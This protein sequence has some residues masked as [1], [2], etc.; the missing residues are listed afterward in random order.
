MRTFLEVWSDPGE[1]GRRAGSRETRKQPRQP[2]RLASAALI[3][4]LGAVAPPLAWSAG[5]GQDQQ[6]PALGQPMEAVVR[7]GTPPPLTVAAVMTRPAV[8]TP[9]PSS[10]PV[11]FALRIGSVAVALLATLLFLTRRLAVASGPPVEPSRSR[12]PAPLPVKQEAET[13]AVAANPPAA[14]APQ[15]SVEACAAERGPEYIP[16]SCTLKAIE[17]DDS[18][19][20]SELEDFVL[21]ALGPHPERADLR[22]KLLEFYHDSGDLQAFNEQARFYILYNKGERGFHWDETRRMG[23]DL[24]PAWTLQKLIGLAPNA[25]APRAPG[26]R[27]FYDGLEQ[28]PLDAALHGLQR[29][30]HA[31]RNDPAFLAAI[32]DACSAE[33]GQPT[34]YS[35]SEALSREIGGARIYIKREDLR[36]V[37][38]DLLLNA[39][40]QVTLAKWSGHCAAVAGFEDRRHAEA[41]ARAARSLDIAATICVPREFLARPDQPTQRV[42]KQSGAHLVLADE[43]DTPDVDGRRSAM[44]R[45]LDAP[46]ETQYVSSLRT[47][48][49]PFPAM[50]RDFQ[51]LI[52]QEIR[53]QSF[54]QT[55][56]LPD[57]IVANAAAGP[58]AFGVIQS[59]L[60]DDQVRID[61]VEPQDGLAAA[62]WG[63]KAPR[64][65]HEL[66]WSRR[67]NRVNFCPVGAR[68]ITAMIELCGR[69]GEA[70]PDPR[71]ACTL[72]QAI[73][74][75]RNAPRESSVMALF[76]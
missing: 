32:M 13:L 76:A 38:A 70:V 19:L 5:P 4:V 69:S 63:G 22:F 43:D 61:C 31:A 60:N 11:D 28:E 55:G 44:R 15:A 39:L 53:C 67:T 36:P 3:A 29:A 54:C 18:G 48:P 1:I 6:P 46:G 68:E 10:Q 9:A 24:D 71:N 27:R 7:P 51:S 21:S 8:L 35:H 17:V 66:N 42:V 41:V 49:T 47:S 75:A 14:G 2:R 62:P 33:L 40:G 34:P 52:G 57:V 58:A 25:T 37:N 45:W 56:G 72:A 50:V 73:A 64:Y 16:L 74:V 59:F 23:L 20:C 26:T 12:A 30:W 65:E